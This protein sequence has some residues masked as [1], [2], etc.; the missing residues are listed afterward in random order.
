MTTTLNVP[1][2]TDFTTAANSPVV[3]GTGVTD[4]TFTSS[5]FA[6]AT[7]N[8]N[9]FGGANIS[10]ALHVTGSATSSNK[11]FVQ[12]SSA[13]SFSGA[14]WTFSNWDNDIDRVDIFGSSGNDSITG[15]SQRDFIRAGAGA[16]TINGGDGDDN[17]VLGAGLQD[18]GETIDGGNGSD[19]LNV[20]NNQNVDLRTLNFTSIER[21]G[22]GPGSTAN[23]RGDQIGGLNITDI[24]SFGLTPT[25]LNV[26]GTSVDLSNVVFFWDD[27]DIINITGSQFE[28]NTLHGSV[29]KDTITGCDAED[30]IFGGGGADVLNG[31]FSN[32]SFRFSNAAQAPQAITI[33]GGAQID[34]ITL[35]AGTNYSF[36]SAN[37]VSVERLDF[38][39]FTQSA[40]F[41]S[42]QLGSGKINTFNA[43][44]GA[45]TITVLMDNGSFS[46]A[47]SALS[48]FSSDDK[49]VISDTLDADTII[50]SAINDH[51]TVSTGAD[52]VSGGGGNDSFAVNTNSSHVGMTLNG[53]TGLEDTLALT[54]SGSISFDT[55]TL[56]NVEKLVMST[57]GGSGTFAGDGFGTA[58]NLLNTVTGTV[59]IDQIKVSGAVTDLTNIAF[60]NWSDGT[61]SIVLLGTLGSDTLTGS[62]KND[63]IQNTTGA[64][65]LKGG[66]GDDTFTMTGSQ[67][68]AGDS[69]DGGNGLNDTI[70]V[71]GLAGFA[72]VTITNVETLALSRNTTL[73]QNA[74]V[75]FK[76]TQIGVGAI[77]TVVGSV[78]AETLLI[79]GPGI[80]L[81]SVTFTNWTDGADL[82][83]I[84]GDANAN[85][86]IGSN[87]NDLINGSNGDDILA[88]GL[89]ADKLNGGANSDTADYRNSTGSNIAINLELAA[90][91][92][93]H[94][95]GDVLNSI[96]NLM[97]SLIQRDILIGDGNRNNIFGFGG[98]DSLRGG[99]DDDYLEGGAGGDAINGDAGTGDTAGYRASNAGT[100]NIS[101]LANTASGGDAEGDVLFFIENLEGSLTRRDILIGN[102][103]A[104][105]IIGNDGD[106]SIRG[107]GGND[108]LEGGRGAD[109]INGGANIDTVTYERS[110]LGVTI[111]LNVALQSSAGDAAGDT[112]NFIEDIIGSGQSD[113]I[114][115]NFAANH[116]TGGAGSDTLNGGLGSD[117][118]T[119]G[120]EADTFRFSDLSF[121]S[122]TITDWQDGVDK[123][124]IAAVLET[125]FVGLTFTG[126][127][128]TDVTVRGFNGTGSAIVVH[129]TAAFTLDAGDFLFV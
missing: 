66:L 42:S 91:S 44:G 84:N 122:D 50:G 116:F 32:D 24:S 21:L 4:L 96:E 5:A 31:G 27:Q 41:R 112:L 47:T 35:D 70:A 25:T 16:D 107:E 127:G 90:A 49:F 103:I 119:G 102:D 105:R 6:S 95:E 23:L 101:L 20:S 121:G 76:S 111:D 1:V 129:A 2:T 69:I 15:T 93:G 80:D 97:G 118:L 36:L 63:V 113:A 48:G 78:D 109:S 18:A 75:G 56:V 58:A 53:N 89:G 120:T 26:S 8:A 62:A 30:E 13:G 88:G 59:A 65:T 126:N 11:I 19:L 61:D 43:T 34:K 94:A 81:S 12:M 99:G 68:N 14:G 128:T 106:D 87:R 110:A 74:L 72:N 54:G 108:M 123:I 85:V 115:G 100:V 3:T 29:F 51:I 73:G 71:S 60:D 45:K 9:Q 82:I 52:V 37:I 104:N 114:T 79:S 98:I 17:I 64:D 10:N 39:G 77:V 92:G 28:Q 40:G 55:S 57:S 22:I 83:S 33:N 117:T 125:S 67:T 86:L 7:F 38:F 124:S 46:L